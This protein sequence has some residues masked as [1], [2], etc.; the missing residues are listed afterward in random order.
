ML[1]LGVVPAYSLLANRVNRIKLITTVTL[2]FVVC[3]IAFDVLANLGIPVAFPFFAWLGIFSLRRGS[4]S[5]IGACHRHRRARN[6]AQ[7]ARTP[8]PRREFL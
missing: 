4:L 5:I 7:E 8:L 1:L 6:R 3:L 2:I